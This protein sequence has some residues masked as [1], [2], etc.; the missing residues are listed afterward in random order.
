VRRQLNPVITKAHFMRTAMTQTDGT[1]AQMMKSYQS[2]LVEGEIPEWG[3]AEYKTWWE[4]QY[5]P[6]ESHQVEA[7]PPMYVQEWA[8]GYV[9][10]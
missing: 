7:H 1:L 3:T 2:T 4:S 5:D 9:G 8:D 10:K 6:A